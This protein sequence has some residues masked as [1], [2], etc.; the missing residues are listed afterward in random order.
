MARA[1]LDTWDQLAANMLAAIEAIDAERTQH[2]GDRHC[3]DP[4]ANFFEGVER[5]LTDVKGRPYS[6]PGLCNDGAA[7]A[8]LRRVLLVI[9]AEACG[10][11]DGT[12]QF[13]GN[14]TWAAKVPE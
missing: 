6:G 7:L 12:W 3:C 4:Y 2:I 11:R 13:R 9:H 1:Y 10:R 14:K 8:R 5:P